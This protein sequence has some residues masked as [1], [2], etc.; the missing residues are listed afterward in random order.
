MTIGA[1]TGMLAAVTA[2]IAKLNSSAI[3]GAVTCA[4]AAPNTFC[5]WGGF[6]DDALHVLAT[7]NNQV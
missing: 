3:E 6:L 2:C 4:N 7:C 5:K 1:F